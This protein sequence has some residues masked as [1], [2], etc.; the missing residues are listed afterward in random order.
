MTPDR[1]RADEV[2]YFFHIYLRMRLERQLINGELAV[3][4]LPEAWNAA[5]KDSLGLEPEGAAHGCLQDVHWFVGK[6]GYFPS[7]TLGHMMAAQFHQTM[8]RQIQDLP[9][10]LRAGDFEPVRAWLNEKVHSRGRLLGREE[11]MRSV[12][13]APLGINAL[14]AHIED[15]YLLAA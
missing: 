9:E 6:F 1:K 11:L 4:D 10:R 13:G 3:K 15:R 2:T 14:V 5:L 12:T 7:Y 8:K